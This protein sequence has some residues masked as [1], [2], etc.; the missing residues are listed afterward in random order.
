MKR[1]IIISLLL[2]CCYGLPL[3]AQNT[4]NVV[5][6]DGVEI[7][8]YI[9][10]RADRTVS[11]TTKELNNGQYNPYDTVRIPA[12]VTW[13]DMVWNITQISSATFANCS[14]LRHVELPEGI[15]HIGS[16]A[17]T[18]TGILSFCMPSTVTEVGYSCFFANQQMTEIELSSGLTKLSNGMLSSCN[19]LRFLKVPEG[20]ITID[21]EA[22][23]YCRILDSISLPSTLQEIKHH[24]FVYNSA[25][26][27]IT[28]HAVV[29]PMVEGSDVFRNVD[30]ETTVLHVPAGCI[31]AYRN[32]PVWSEF[33]NIQDDA[34]GIAT[35][36]TSALRWHVEHN[37][38]VVESAQPLPATLYDAM[39]RQ[40]LRTTLQGN[41]R[42][43]VP[44]SGLYILRHG[45][46][47]NKIIVP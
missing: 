36:E 23:R 33:V 1:S 14:T 18:L 4:F 8:Y 45:N 47:S 13:D 32:A 20:V 46:K 34:V 5:N 9:L 38:I 31:E 24:A 25:L 27:A 10:S 15:T 22:V 37:A 40:V 2:V 43:D 39:G 44:H 19:R 35:T 6:D 28:V 21:T 17:F 41:T 29:P 7:S 42:L 26:S 30:R 11:V 12:T 3:Q 16:Y